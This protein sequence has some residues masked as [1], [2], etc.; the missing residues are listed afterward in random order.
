MA[1]LKMKN[2]FKM[3]DLSLETQDLILALVFVVYLISNV[4]LPSALERIIDTTSGNIIVIIMALMTLMMFNPIVGVLALIT[5]Y[6]LMR[7]T[8]VSNSNILLKQEVPSEETK[9]HEMEVLNK[10]AKKRTLEEEMIEDVKVYVSDDTT[11]SNIKPLLSNLHN[12]SNLANA[13]SNMAPPNAMVNK[14]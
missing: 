2:L 4:K 9:R 5:A 10:E 13:P 7:R 14:A 1:G 6:E 12:A 8:S 11:P 3:K